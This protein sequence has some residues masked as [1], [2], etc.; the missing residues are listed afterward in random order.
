MRTKSISK[1]RKLLKTPCYEAIGNGTH[2]RPCFQTIDEAS[3]QQL[4]RKYP[5]VC[6]TP[7]GWQE[8]GIPC[9]I[10][11]FIC[12]L[13]VSLETVQ[14]VY[15]TNPTVESNWSTD[16]GYWKEI[17]QRAPANVLEFLLNKYPHIVSTLVV[18]AIL[19]WAIHLSKRSNV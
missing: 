19:L 10:L 4:V 2:R 7:Y 13:G 12:S 5:Q 14:L 9:Y 6:S 8:D 11:L 15:N 1:F 3:L 16:A 18:S 17:L